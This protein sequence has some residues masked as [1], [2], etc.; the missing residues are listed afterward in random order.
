MELFGLLI[1]LLGV[2]GLI[3]FLF[4]LMKKLNKMTT[5]SSGSK[6]RIIDRANTGRDSSLLVVS[7]GGRLMLIGVSTGRIEKLSD[8]DISEEDYLGSPE[9]P[10]KQGIRFSDILNNLV[11]KRV[12]TDNT[13]KGEGE[14]NTVEPDNQTSDLKEE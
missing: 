4:Y 10:D 1:S 9:N 8:L 14:E 6:L 3:L 2:I 13:P 5:V 11:K 12:V 7:I